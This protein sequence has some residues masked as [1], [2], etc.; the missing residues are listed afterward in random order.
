M[1]KKNLPI[2][3]LTS[4]VTL[5]PMV[6]GLLLWNSLP[7]QIPLHWNAEG[8]VDGYGSKAMAVFGLP[9][10][11]LAMQWLCMLMT[12][13]DP[14]HKNIDAKPLTLVLWICPILCAFI[15]CLMYAAALGYAVSVEIL[16]PLFLGALFVVIGNY[17]PKCRQSY[18]LGIKLPWTLDDPE[19]W[20]N[21]HRLAGIVWVIGGVVIMATAFLGKFWIMMSK[22]AVMVLAPTVYSYSLYRRKKHK[23]E[24]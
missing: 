23:A 14:K 11:V 21:T 9:V 12:S 24:D 18:T 2:L 13:L 8:A 5:L 10:F 17:L 22:L 1:I 16:M 3:L 19:N 6:I 4:V 7:E 15:S 20:Y